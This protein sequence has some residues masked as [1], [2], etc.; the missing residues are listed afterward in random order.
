M[1]IYT[2]KPVPPSKGALISTY[3]L[4]LRGAPTSTHQEGLWMEVGS[5]ARPYLSHN[6]SPSTESTDLA[7]C[8]TPSAAW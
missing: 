7:E 4:W 6:D 1:E 5:F 3:R 2:K 8:I